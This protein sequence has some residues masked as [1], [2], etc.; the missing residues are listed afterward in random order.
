MGNSTEQIAA[1][2]RA[3]PPP[4]PACSYIL[5]RLPEISQACAYQ[6]GLRRAMCQ[7]QITGSNFCTALGTAYMQESLKYCTEDAREL[8]EAGAGK[9]AYSIVSAQDVHITALGS[10]AREVPRRNL[11][12][13][14]V[15]SGEKV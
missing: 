10:F 4:T 3:A 1:N 12:R 9:W 6:S 15:V 5:H 7:L 13:A 14:V 11:R 8:T 2:D